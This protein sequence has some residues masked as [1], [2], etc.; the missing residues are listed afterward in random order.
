MIC[1]TLGNR[2][3]CNVTAQLQQWLCDTKSSKKNEEYLR[4]EYFG[5]EAWTQQY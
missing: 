3:S 1:F 5:S 4:D 2:R